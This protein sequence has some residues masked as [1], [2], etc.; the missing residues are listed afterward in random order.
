[1]AM[2]RL[3]LLKN[4][5]SPKDRE[6]HEIE[7]SVIDWL[8]ADA[9]DGYGA[10]IGWYLNGAP[11]RN[12]DLDYI[13]KPDDYIIIAI[14]PAGGLFGG[15]IFGAI[16][17]AL[18][19]FA[20]SKLINSVFGN[21]KP[22]SPKFTA[23]PEPSPVYSIANHQ[24]SARLGYP[25]PVIYGQCLH[26][27]D[28]ISQP[29]TFFKEKFK[30]KGLAD[31]VTTAAAASMT[32]NA[33]PDYTNHFDLRNG[34][35]TFVVVYHTSEYLGLRHELGMG[36]TDVNRMRDPYKPV[37]KLTFHQEMWWEGTKVAE[38]PPDTEHILPTGEHLKI[39]LL[40]PTTVF[41]AG[42][43][44]GIKGVANGSVGYSPW[45]MGGNPPSDWVNDW[46]PFTPYDLI[47]QPDK[48][49]MGLITINRPPV[50]SPTAGKDSYTYYTLDPA[51]M[52]HLKDEL[53]V[54]K[55]AGEDVSACGESTICGEAVF[56]N[57]G[58]LMACLTR[59]EPK[60]SQHADGLQC[61]TGYWH[62]TDR[63]EDYS[64]NM[65][66]D[67]TPDPQQPNKRIRTRVY[68]ESWKVNSYWNA[69]RPCTPPGYPDDSQRGNELVQGKGERN[70]GWRWVIQEVTV[71]N[72]CP[73]GYWKECP[74]EPCKPY[75][76]V[77]PAWTEYGTPTKYAG[78]YSID[79]YV[80]P[81]PH[82]LGD[83]YLD[84][85]LAI[86][87]GEHQID[88][89]LLGNTPIQ[90]LPQGVVQYDHYVINQHF[91][92]K[93]NVLPFTDFY[94]N[95]VTCP[96]VGDQEF[97]M[98]NETCGW[99][100]TSKTGVKG[101]E[102]QID[103]V[104]P[105]G[106]FNM[107]QDGS[108][109]NHTC[110]WFVEWREVDINNNP[111]T[112]QVF[113]YKETLNADTNQT[114]RYTYQY[115]MGKS[116]YWQFRI[117]R[118]TAQDPD[119]QTQSNFHW[120]ALKLI[121]DIEP[122]RRLYGNLHVLSV[123]IKATNGIASEATRK[124]FVRASRY[125]ENP[126]DGK[127]RLTRSPGD[128]FVDI[129][130]NRT[131]GAR[132]PLDEINLARVD[133]FKQYWE[134][135]GDRYHFNA[136]YTD[137]VTV[138]E[139]LTE[140]V[141]GVIAQPLPLGSYM[142]I[143]QDGVKPIRTVLYSENNMVDGTLNLSYNFDSVD[144]FDGV[145]VR[146]IEHDTWN[147]N[148]V[149]YPDYALNPD[150]IV[151]FG[152]TDRQHALEYAKLRWQRLRG[153]RQYTGFET[154]LEGFIPELGDRFALSN[155]LPEWGVSG[156]VLE[157][158]GHTLRLDKPVEFSNTRQNYMILR[159]ETG[160]PH[161]PIR[162]AQAAQG[163]DYISLETLP[164]FP[165]YIGSDQEN[166]HYVFGHGED[167]VRDFVIGDLEHKGGV[168]VAVNGVIYAPEIFNDTLAY[169]VD[170]VPI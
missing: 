56:T 67:W 91:E 100:A 143:V 150:E 135:H 169:L 170:P 140:S 128:A 146:Y 153:Q 31:G 51:S 104:F 115:D 80:A 49:H 72:S 36:G 8:Q 151:L 142:S 156:L 158:V 154:E 24:N 168:V 60:D 22:D 16:I 58:D 87:Q 114:L 137:R 90:H 93:D 84:M 164:S 98:A 23:P 35:D 138:F 163:P 64:F 110:E 76:N 82:P 160:V 74:N 79:K 162:C 65:T 108:L 41:G 121:G 129:Y 97:Y 103:I 102:V 45:F 21:K 40:V 94:E 88:E 18:V 73:P 50:D 148:Y 44:A 42:R 62:Y 6:D 15:G 133:K 46:A 96:E 9:P 48:P 1:M 78:F 27:P 54:L 152:C 124:L 7:G 37:Y 125:L 139:A 17:G 83:E 77:V 29:Y 95:M 38:W 109:V 68:E 145:E 136:I 39:G 19:N 12:D 118:I 166:T 117:T 53:T 159:S 55:A 111:V 34:H 85:I 99:Y 13:V 112:G 132:R 130:T 26:I 155:T 81:E 61:H 57:I 47:G 147:P 20:V 30:R 63:V 43:A 10:P 59:R 66:E 122:E 89:I 165:I 161:A 33:N 101:K 127:L 70:L 4:P 11:M 120:R 3:T 123:R 141:Q 92:E 5:L 14:L 113:Q 134:S 105:G 107:Q 86:G 69:D 126:H 25:V 167:V 144:A 119:T 157:Q 116:A 52:Q 32:V 131:Y 2:A 71:D 28:Y 75:I 106:L 149:R